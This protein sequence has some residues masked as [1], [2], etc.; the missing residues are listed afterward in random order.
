MAAYLIVDVDNLV[1][2]FETRGIAVDFQELAV[3]LRGGA[4]LAAG[5]MTPEKLRAVAVANWDA[6]DEDTS[7]NI[8][9]KFV[10]HAAGYDTF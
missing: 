2:Q 8:D 7:R 5:L 3:G 1:L 10:F 9:P 4:A 6:Y